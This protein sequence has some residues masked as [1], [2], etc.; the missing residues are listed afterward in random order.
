MATLRKKRKLAA[1]SSETKSARN[2]QSQN[3]FVPGLNED[4]ITQFLEEVEGS[5]T[6]KLSQEY[7]RTESR[8]LGAL[9]KPE[10]IV[11]NPQVG[12]CSRTFPG[13]SRNST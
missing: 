6:K 8:I 2:S 11:L 1:V 10:E 4:Y 12:T 3:T 5:I 9:S 13:T 7:S